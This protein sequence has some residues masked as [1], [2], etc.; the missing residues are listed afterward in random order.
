[1]LEHSVLAQ[2]RAPG[3]ADSVLRAIV[4]CCVQDGWGIAT[5]GSSLIISDSGPTLYW[6]DGKTLK[7]HRRVDVHDGMRKVPWVNE[8][9]HASGLYQRSSGP[10]DR[11]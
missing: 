10:R 9:R 3:C 7:E 2:R 1:M 5:D 11:G 6:L 8:V 4:T